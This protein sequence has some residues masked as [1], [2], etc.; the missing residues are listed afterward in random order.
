MGNG[1][2][3]CRNVQVYFQLHSGQKCEPTVQI[4]AISASYL[5]PERSN[6]D[7]LCS[8]LFSTAQWAK[9]WA[10]HKFVSYLRQERS[11][12]D[13]L[14]AQNHLLDVTNVVKPWGRVQVYFK[15]DIGQECEPYGVKMILISDFVVLGGR[16]IFSVYLTVCMLQTS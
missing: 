5:R 9:M 10:Y 16:E 7:N 3:P 4:L 11:K 15:L 1:G 13:I 12:C 2:K 14:K 6:W 8:S